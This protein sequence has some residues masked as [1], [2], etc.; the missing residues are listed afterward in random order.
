MVLM[1]GSARGEDA[2]RFRS[3]VSLRSYEWDTIWEV[4]DGHGVSYGVNFNRHWGL[5]LAFDAFEKELE[6]SQGRLVAEQSAVGLV[7]LAR[8]RLPLLQDRLVPYVVAGVGGTFMQ[9]NDRKS[10]AF[11]V[12]LDAEGWG[13]TAVGGVG[14]E[15]FLDDNITFGF[16]GKYTW[17][18]ELDTRIGSETGSIDMSAFLLSFG[19]RVYFDENHPRALA[20]DVT[21]PRPPGTRLYFGVRPGSHWALD[22]DWGGGVELS[23]TAQNAST[24]MNKHYGFLLG[25]QL[26][27]NWAGELGLDGGEMNIRVD[28]K[29]DIAEYAQVSIGPILRYRWP[30][31][32]GRWV[33]YLLVGGGL[34]YAESNDAKPHSVKFP[35]LETDGFY[36]AVRGG[37]GFEYFVG[38]NVSFGAELNYEYTW[39]HEITLPDRGTLEG[40]MSSLQALLVMRLYLLEL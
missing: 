4:H 31:A 26:N 39:G 33:P 32:S 2:D 30:L 25:A 7:P 13:F 5:E 17:I 18:E 9:A 1:T 22:G 28:D 3:F 36:G 34:Q 23:N 8:F 14:I 27:R 35:G 29:Y 11:G 6:N 19:F 20:D 16:E 40:N 10:P 21:A 15:Y 37:G 24:G 12:D 38:R